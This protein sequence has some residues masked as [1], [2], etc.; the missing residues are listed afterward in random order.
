MKILI[1]YAYFETPDAKRNLGFFCRHAVTPLRDRHHV[2][3]VNGAC[4]IE[5]QIPRFENVTLVRRDNKGF[6]FGAWAHALR[7]VKLE[8]FDYFFLLNSSVTG[9]F[10]PLYEDSAHWP[11]LFLSMLS[12]RVK[13]VGITM[14]NWWQRDPTVHSMF[15]ATDRTGLTLLHKTGI[16]TGN[17]GDVRKIEDVVLKREAGCSKS[18]LAAGFSIDCLALSHSKHSL[19][20]QKAGPHHSVHGPSAYLH[21]YSLEPLDT[22]FFKTNRDSSPAALERSMQ[23]ADYKRATAAERCFQDARI[24]RTIEALK[25]VPS[26]WRSHVEFA[27]WLTCRFLPQVVV[28]LGVESGVSTY[29]WGISGLSQTV[30][31]D[32]FRADSA[33]HVAVLALAESLARDC[34]YEETV[35]IWKASPKDASRAFKSKVDV[36]HVD[37]TRAHETLKRDLRHWISK[38]SKGGIVLVHGTRTRPDSVRKVFDELDGTKIHLDYGAGLGVVSSDGTKIATIDREWSRSL[39]LHGAEVRHADFYNLSMYP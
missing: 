37:G 21:G 34:G 22:V 38:L 6:D 30:G 4:S 15:L 29:A 3:V 11:E 35:R 39:R 16:F 12:D 17:D 32:E 5:D 9:P 2:I 7:T 18:I 28:D 13:L 31:V 27:V 26:T 23:L 24:L 14:D 20:L 36:L 1:V 25:R 33:A 19:A 10:L 8:Q